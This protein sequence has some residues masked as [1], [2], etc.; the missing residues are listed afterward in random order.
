[1]VLASGASFMV[2]FILVWAL[3]WIW[4]WLYIKEDIDQ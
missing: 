3:I 4:A 1:M 2:P